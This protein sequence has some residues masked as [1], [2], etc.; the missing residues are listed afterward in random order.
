MEDF[1]RVERVSIENF[2]IWFFSARR[3]L[4]VDAAWFGNVEGTSIL[5]IHTQFHW[6]SFVSVEDTLWPVSRTISTAAFQPFLN[7][8]ES[9][10]RRCGVNVVLF[11]HGA[12]HGLV[13]Q[14]FIRWFLKVDQES[15]WNFSKKDDDQEYKKT[16]PTSRGILSRYRSSLGT[17]P[18]SSEPHRKGWCKCLW[19]IHFS[20]ISLS[21]DRDAGQTGAIN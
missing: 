15:G 1:A 9:C 16:F 21:V 12:H 18:E 13:Y 11:H 8:I 14:S 3:L 19:N 6:F 7:E 5:C 4:G 17:P 20:R 2:W 10:Y